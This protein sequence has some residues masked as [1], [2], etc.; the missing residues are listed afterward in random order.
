[1]SLLN[2]YFCCTE[3]ILLA[4]CCI[5]LIFDIKLNLSW[6]AKLSLFT[7]YVCSLLLSIPYTLSLIIYST[8]LLIIYGHVEQTDKYHILYYI[9]GF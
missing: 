4:M 9:F 2:I 7:Y 8:I 5:C 6:V 1:M 3:P